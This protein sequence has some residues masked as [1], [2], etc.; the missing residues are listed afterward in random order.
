[1]V[2]FHSLIC[3]ALFP[4][5][6]QSLFSR[7]SAFKEY[8]VVFMER[9]DG[10]YC[11]ERTLDKNDL[12]SICV[13]P[14]PSEQQVPRSEFSCLSRVI[15]SGNSCQL[16]LSLQGGRA[17][18]LRVLNENRVDGRRFVVWQEFNV[19]VFLQCFRLTHQAVF[20]M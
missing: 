1:M 6:L 7:V 12:L 14:E 17:S 15:D 10:Q 13:R 19:D 4:R 18:L 11:V 9:V 3:R 8:S 16:P 5:V 2:L 20:G